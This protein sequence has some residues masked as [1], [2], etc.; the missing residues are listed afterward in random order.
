MNRLIQP[1]VKVT[2][3]QG[4]IFNVTVGRA[5]NN[6]NGPKYLMGNPNGK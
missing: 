6:I 1:R 5:A 4:E 3:V 2:L